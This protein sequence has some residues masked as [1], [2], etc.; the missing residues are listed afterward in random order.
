MTNRHHHDQ[1]HHNA[2][3]C[4]LV[5]IALPFAP[6]T[7]IVCPT[8]VDRL[9]FPSVGLLWCSTP[10]LYILVVLLSFGF[11][12]VISHTLECHSYSSGRICLPTTM[13]PP[14]NFRR[15]LT[16]CFMREELVYSFDYFP[17]KLQFWQIFH[18]VFQEDIYSLARKFHLLFSIPSLGESSL[19]VLIS[20]LCS[21]RVLIPNL[22]SLP[23]HSLQIFSE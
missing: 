10:A 3:C 12:P 16:V 5:F 6:P 19:R 2:S 4:N 17:I 11:I 1:V 7:S 23:L 9:P 15:I 18:L 8:N 13:K 22:C 14:A 20:K 21:S